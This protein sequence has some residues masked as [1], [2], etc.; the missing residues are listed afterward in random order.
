MLLGSSSL[1]LRGSKGSLFLSQ[2]TVFLM[3]HFQPALALAEHGS[4]QDERTELP[5]I[6]GII[7]S[8]PRKSWAA[9]GQTTPKS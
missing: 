7:Q 9:V 6:A 8:T 2:W 5:I 1:C 3:S 4:D